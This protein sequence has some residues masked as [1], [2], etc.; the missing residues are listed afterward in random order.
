MDPRH[1]GVKVEGTETIYLSTVSAG[2]TL[3]LSVGEPYENM[4]KTYLTKAKVQELMARLSIW[5]EMEWT[6]TY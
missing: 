3:V 6:P 1:Y 4:V 5:L 2:Q